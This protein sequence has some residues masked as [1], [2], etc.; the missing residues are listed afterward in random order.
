MY[1]N[2]TCPQG[3]LCS[4]QTKQF[5]KRKKHKTAGKIKA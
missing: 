2:G 4:R 3:A 1:K 5:A